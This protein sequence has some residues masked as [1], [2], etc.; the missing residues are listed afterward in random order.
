[1]PVSIRASKS[2]G[3]RGDVQNFGRYQAPTAPMLTQ[4]L[5]YSILMVVN[6]KMIVVFCLMKA[7]VESL[8]MCYYGQ[9]SDKKFGILME[10]GFIWHS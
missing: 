9:D 6:P 1:M 4:A 2:A 3:A 5:R 7:N 10:K 8:L